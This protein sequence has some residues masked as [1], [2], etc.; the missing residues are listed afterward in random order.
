[1]KYVKMEKMMNLKSIIAVLFLVSLCSCEEDNDFV[2]TNKKSDFNLEVRQSEFSYDLNGEKV[3]MLEFDSKEDFLNTIAL[4]EQ[5]DEYY[6]DLFYSKFQNEFD[7]DYSYYVIED[8]YD[9]DDQKVYKDYEKSYNYISMRSIYELLEKNWLESCKNDT[10]NA[11]PDF[12]NLYPY[13]IAE[14][15]L[16]NK[17]GEVKIGDSILKVVNSDYIVL[18]AQILP[19]WLNTI[20][21]IQVF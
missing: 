7:A 6:T 10:L 15:T 11:Y 5:E 2:G 3:Y 16:F 17:Y 8:D 18:E 13:S 9:F 19:I 12:E 21:E 1:M 20:L 14:Q 4:L